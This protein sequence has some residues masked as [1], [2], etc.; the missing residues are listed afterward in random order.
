MKSPKNRSWVLAY[1]CLAAILI[2]AFCWLREMTGLVNLLVGAEPRPGEWRNAALETIL[3]LLA[4]WVVF[5]PTW[6]L[7]GHLVYLEKFVR[8]CAWCRK[9]C[10]RE[11]WLPLEEYFERGL[12]VG[13][14]HGIC[15]ECLMKAKEDTTRFLRRA[16][17]ETEAS[18]RSSKPAGQTPEPIV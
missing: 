10:Y 7:V 14:T 11:E 15:P 17:S 6:R 13:T 2:I 1:E 12:H 8:V 18:A 9:V 5:A 16:A 4:W 3:I